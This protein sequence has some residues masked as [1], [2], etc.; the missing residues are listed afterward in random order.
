MN[1]V[2]YKP[3]EDR[4]YAEIEQ[5]T[6]QLQAQLNR[7]AQMIQSGEL[8]DFKITCDTGTKFH[9]CVDQQPL[10]TYQT[11]PLGSKGP[12]ESDTPIPPSDLV[13]MIEEVLSNNYSGGIRIVKNILYYMHN[14]VAKEIA[15]LLYNARIRDK[16]SMVREL[17]IIINKLSSNP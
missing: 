15:Q 14:E 11:S 17:E 16:K 3:M 13:K 2:P 5:L 1:L 6:A 12:V 10:R 8:R 9:M 7:I 4:I